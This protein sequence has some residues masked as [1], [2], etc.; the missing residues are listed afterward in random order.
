MHSL[1]KLGIFRSCFSV[2]T[3]EF[4]QNHN[5]IT[6]FEYDVGQKNRK[7]KLSKGCTNN[8]WK[9]DGNGKGQMEFV[10]KNKV[11][12]CCVL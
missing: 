9:V 7:K 10:I 6:N 4:S 2:F 8:T 12:F 3:N 11:L 1:P 5:Y